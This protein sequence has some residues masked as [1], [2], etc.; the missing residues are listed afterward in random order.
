M[1]AQASEPAHLKD[2]STA[3][4]RPIAPPDRRA[5]VATF[6]RLSPE[7]RYRRFLQPM[8]RLTERVLDY[9]IDVDHR[10]REALLAL[11]GIT[12]EPLAVARYARSLEDRRSAEFAVAVVDHAQ[13]KGLGIAILRRLADHAR[14]QGITHFTGLVL[15]EN[16]PMLALLGELGTS[17]ARR[18]EAGTLEVTVEL[19]PGDGIGAG[20]H[21]WLRAAAAEEVSF[22]SGLRR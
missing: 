7:S 20:L 21:R 10:D 5:L 17:T 22:D 3:I 14:A 6:E 8:T 18:A 4:I 11:D 19:P 15:T 13:G 1:T 12:G 9:L 16:R 2:G